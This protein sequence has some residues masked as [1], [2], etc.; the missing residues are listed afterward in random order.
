VVEPRTGTTKSP[1]K[2]LRLVSSDL[3]LRPLKPIRGCVG[4]HSLLSLCQAPQH[5]PEEPILAAQTR[6]SALGLQN[7]Q[8]LAQRQNLQP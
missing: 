6:A 5:D 4:R 7:G 3:K 8:P 2:L 1:F